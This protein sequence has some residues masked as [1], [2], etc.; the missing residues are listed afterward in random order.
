M[1]ATLREWRVRT[2]AANHAQ[3]SRVRW[4]LDLGILV[5]VLAALAYVT[6][7]VIRLTSS[8]SSFYWYSDFPEALR[9][10]DAVFHHGYGQGLSVPAQTGIGPLWVVGMLDQVTGNDIVGMTVG[11]LIV[12]LAVGLMAWTAYRVI[13]RVGAV[14]VGVLCVAAP[15]VVAWEMLT[16]VAHESTV[17]LAGIAAWQLVSLSQP[18]RGRAIASSALVGAVAGVCVISDALAIPAAVA[19]W[20]ICAILLV[21]RNH[22]RLLPIAITAMAAIAS[23]AAVVLLS[24]ASGIAARGGV[25]LAPS[26]DGVTAGLHSVATTLGQMISGAWYTEALPAVALI[27]FVAFAAVIFMA[28]RAA[29]QPV[30]DPVRGCDVYAWFWLL[31]CAALIAAYCLSGLGPQRSPVDYQGHYVD[32]LWFA[33][34]ALLPLGFLWVGRIRRMLLVACAASLAVVSTVGVATAPSFLLNGPDYVDTARLTSTLESVGATRGYGGYW[35]SYAVG[36]HT[37]NRITA[38]PL[39]QCGSGLC[40]YAFAAPAWYQRQPGS[41]FVIVQVS[42]CSHDPLCIDAANLEGLPPPESVH[43]VG[44]LRVYVYPHD[45]FAGLPAAANL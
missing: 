14:V 17:L 16:P 33:I 8:L 22:S 29:R 36:W 30:S 44:P 25:G 2:P 4:W 11:A 42:G 6:V 7:L 21:R 28:T 13:G 32:E 45:V 43:A 10:G 1:I 3:A 27:G 20:I 38:L 34:A 12:V 35:E 23:A 39:Q 15:P 9:L 41:V 5:P 37:D 40:R 31:V 19:P 26:I 18:A 24:S